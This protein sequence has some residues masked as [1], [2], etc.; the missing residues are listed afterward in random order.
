MVI[1]TITALCRSQKIWN[2]TLLD[3]AEVFQVS[4]HVPYGAKIPLYFR[5]KSFL[6]FLLNKTNI[7]I[8]SKSNVWISWTWKNLWSNLVQRGNWFFTFCNLFFAERF[9]TVII[10]FCQAKLIETD[11]FFCFLWGFNYFWSLYVL[12][13]ILCSKISWWNTWIFK[14][15]KY[16]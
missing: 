9:L 13:L 10:S 8:C 7:L 14:E 3:F 12:F 16:L 4:I 1:T 6:R 11:R 15:I 5:K 2:F